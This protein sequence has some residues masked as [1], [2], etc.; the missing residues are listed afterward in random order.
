MDDDICDKN[1]INE[2]E[3]ILYSQIHHD[4]ADIADN[5]D[6]KSITKNSDP[7]INNEPPAPIRKDRISAGKKINP[8][9]KLKAPQDVSKLDSNPNSIARPKPFTPY[10]SYLAQIDSPPLAVSD[11]SNIIITKKPENSTTTASDGQLSD[12]KPKNRM[13]NP[14][15]Q[16]N[17][18]KR[19]N[20]EKIK[21]KRQRAAKN[22]KFKKPSIISL[23][24]NDEIDMSDDDDV[25]ILP[26]QPISIYSIDDSS[27]DDD[28]ANKQN[29]EN[30]SEQN[31]LNDNV[32]KT[33][34]SPTPSS[35]SAD[36][37]IGQG[38]LNRT[39]ESNEALGDIDD[40]ELNVIRKTV[41][42][43]NRSELTEKLHSTEHVSECQYVEI[44]NDDD[45]AS[46]IKPTTTKASTS[47]QS[48][49]VTDNSFA[50]I[51]VYESESSD[52]PDTVYAMKQLKKSEPKT[53]SDSECSDIIFETENRSKRFKKRKN[54]SSTKG[55]D[56][57]DENTDDDDD[58]VSDIPSIPMEGNMEN[59]TNCIVR[60]EAIANAVT[61]VRKISKT[62]LKKRK[63]LIEQTDQ[64]QSDEE[65]ISML[66]TVV[67]SEF[68]NKKF[69]GYSEMIAGPQKPISPIPI[70]KSSTEWIVTEHKN[71]LSPKIG[72]TNVVPDNNNI[73]I[74]ILDGNIC[75]DVGPSGSKKDIQFTDINLTDKNSTKATAIG[76]GNT[77]NNS[78]SK[79]KGKSVVSCSLGVDPEIG[80]NEEM[81]Y[82]YNKSWGGETHDTSAMQRAMTSNF[83]HFFVVFIYYNIET[84]CF[85][86]LF[87]VFCV[88][89]NEFF[90]CCVNACLIWV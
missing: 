47:N 1:S 36:D 17:Q 54:S 56:H 7:K 40:F 26:S 29:T 82:F 88:K 28:A 6:I 31:Q 25:I 61:D 5:I 33:S 21:K 46:F 64:C 70:Q 78:E 18:D 58:N 3:S 9:A 77:I 52:M 41:E 68:K 48:Y 53:Q 63:N 34:C 27:D 84:Y 50:A 4:P 67:H 79:I 15:S 49:E 19:S 66:S 37:Y 55:S 62:K 60:G 75:L 14:F 23:S 59:S 42:K 13:L 51:D 12:K 90:V 57:Q 69:P 45:D 16:K 30:N 24:S 89:M 32:V 74:N 73:E 8:I 20:A 39:Y 38:N 10:T 65:F 35:A 87:L 43:M 85:I 44:N 86:F 81:K 22:R 2:L 80:W 11:K 83:F 76:G 72:K 71:N